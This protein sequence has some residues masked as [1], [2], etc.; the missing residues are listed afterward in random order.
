MPQYFENSDIKETIEYHYFVTLGKDRYDLIGLNG[1]F[2]KSGIDKGTEFLLETLYRA[3]LG[4]KILDLGCGTGP[5]GL[6]LAKADP[7]R[8]LTMCDVNL[9]ALECAKKNATNLGI[10]PQVEIVESDCYANIDSTFDTIVSNPP[11]R[12]GKKVTYA[13]YDGAPSHLVAGGRLI[14]VVR[15]KQGADSVCAHLATIFS[16]VEILDSHKGYRLIAATK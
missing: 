7:K 12:A 15:R 2:S 11:I 14:V 5:I 9:R 16:K 10:F 3:P 4:N 6:I 1:T 13:F 8:R